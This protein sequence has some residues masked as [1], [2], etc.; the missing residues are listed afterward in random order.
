MDEIEVARPASLDKRERFALLGS[1]TVSH[2]IFHFMSQSFSV[3]IPA[4]KQTFGIS[5]VQIGAIITIRELAS[6]IA[7]LPGGVASD[8]LRRHR[9]LLMAVCMAV[10][11]LGWLMVAVSPDYLLLLAG[12]VAL[13]VASSIWHL[14][15]MA[16]LSVHFSKNRGSAL[17]VH[18]AGGSIGDIFGPV[19]TGLLLGILSWRGII[20]IYAAVPL[21]TALWVAW[22]FGNKVKRQKSGEIER[23]EKPDLKEQL[24][25]TR[26]ILKHSHLWR[27][28]VVAG[29]RGMCFN[30]YVTFL[31]LFMKE[32]LGLSDESVGFHF[33]LL[34]AVGIV[35]SPLMGHLSDRFGRKR[36]LVPALFYSCL[37]T[38]ILALYG[39]G[40]MLTPLIALLGLS[41][42]SDYS[43]LSATILDI[44]GNTV[45]TT[46]LG[47][48]SFTRFILGAVSPLVA[49]ALYQAFGMKATLF[50]VAALF[51]SSAVIFASANLN[52]PRRGNLRF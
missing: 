8:Y 43:I 9:A 10:F 13:A 14:P 32:E 50:F 45:A 44:A 24:K 38:M 33:G 17:A 11:G 23:T 37:L 39:K 27:V 40:A 16:E 6:G 28:N 4:V 31:P 29:F 18:G 41:V 47:V 51:A 5:P 7:S 36:V 25:T 52:L 30:I 15:S 48:L 12:M 35:A 2:G 1:L 42:R 46:M 21:V 49:G 19:A 34:W 26:Y 3:M 22:A 20:S